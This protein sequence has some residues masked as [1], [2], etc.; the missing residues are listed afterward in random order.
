MAG[1]GS[2]SS[3]SSSG[4]AQAR[5][6]RPIALSKPVLNLMI[7]TGAGILFVRVGIR[8]GWIDWPPTQ[9]GKILATLAGWIALAGPLVLF[10]HE[11]QAGSMGVG[12]RV[13][14][15]TG[16]LLWLKLSLQIGTGNLPSVEAV[17]TLI[18]SR[19]MALVSA[20]CL[21]GGMMGKPKNSHWTWTNLVGWGM[22]VCWMTSVLLPADSNFGR[23]LAL[24]MR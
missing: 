13:W 7:L 24:V 4:N 20:A 14:I 10:R 16:L 21:I 22:S 5:N 2:S 12:D 6:T 1:R 3:S 15:T 19:D 18:D 9:L 11:E 17:T 23:I 8:Q